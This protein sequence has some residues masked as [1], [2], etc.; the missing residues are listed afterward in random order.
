MKIQLLFIYCLLS[1]TSVAQTEPRIERIWLETSISSVRNLNSSN[2]YQYKGYNSLPSYL[3][4][5]AQGSSLNWVSSHFRNTTVGVSNSLFQ[6]KKISINQSLGMNLSLANY[7]FRGRIQN[8]STTMFIDVDTLGEP[9]K[10]VV[11]TDYIDRY[12]SIAR[13]GLLYQNSL[14]Y[15]GEKWSFDI[16]LRH[17]LHLKVKDRFHLKHINTQDTTEVSQSSG[18][19]KDDGRT[20]LNNFSLHSIERPPSEGYTAHNRKKTLQYEANFLLK[21]AI[22]VG[23]KKTIEIYGV[24]GLTLLSAYGKD[25]NPL[26]TALHLGIGCVYTIRP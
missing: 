8:Y 5:T 19:W 7:H 13:V 2:V 17:I 6:K 22:K 3:N 4:T 16:V 21:P 1:Y 11:H 18:T 14:H 10:Q 15:S 26:F 9:T 25:Y 24:A 12:K 23:R 20:R